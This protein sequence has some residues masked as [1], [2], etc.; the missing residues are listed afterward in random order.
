M[1]GRSAGD[2][3][4]PE[5][6]AVVARGGIR[7]RVCRLVEYNP[8]TVVGAA[9]PPRRGRGVPRGHGPLVASAHFHAG[10]PGGRPAAHAAVRRDEVGARPFGTSG[11]FLVYT[12]WGMKRSANSPVGRSLLLL[13]TI[14]RMW[15]P[16]TRRH[17][18]PLTT[19]YAFLKAC[20][21]LRAAGNERP[22][23]R[24]GPPRRGR[25]GVS[26]RKT[27]VSGALRPPD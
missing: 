13:L 20:G 8:H 1:K 24:P 9:I 2:D 17:P 3:N 6:R 22:E 18:R 25:G 10:R 27:W 4:P 23:A 26:H 16:R 19:R 5:R 15:M 21:L 14:S 11:V 7:T 12:V